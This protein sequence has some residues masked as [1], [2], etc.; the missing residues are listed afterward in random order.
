MIGVD[1]TESSNRAKAA[2]SS[3]DS[4]VAGRNMTAACSA[5][6]QMSRDASRMD[7]CDPQFLL[8][9]ER[10]IVS[11]K[12]EEGWI[13]GWGDNDIDGDDM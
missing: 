1:I 9:S 13:S 11:G 5:L 6:T 4:G 7:R 8:C 3:M 12:T 10:L 2:N